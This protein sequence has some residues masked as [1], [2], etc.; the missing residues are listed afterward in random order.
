LQ[1]YPLPEFK[2][3]VDEFCK[4]CDGLPLS[5]RVFGALLCGHDQSYWNGQLDKLRQ[6]ELPDEIQKRLKISYD[7]LDKEEERQIFLD[8]SCYFIG[9]DRDMAVRIWDG[10]GWHGLV[11]FRN[12][13]DKCL[14]EVGEKNTIKMH[15]HL[16]DLGRQIADQEKSSG[17]IPHRLWPLIED[18]RGLWQQQSSVSA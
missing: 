11:G 9:E 18:I 4:A 16:R 3:L 1:S 14:V 17:V 15:D 12:L 13:Q 6:I 5:L 10:S 7:A 8:I 2:N